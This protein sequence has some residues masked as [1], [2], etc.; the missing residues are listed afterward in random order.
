MNTFMAKI[1]K[2]MII[3]VHTD[4]TRSTRTVSSGFGSYADFQSQNELFS[5]A[6]GNQ[7]SYGK[8]EEDVEKTAEGNKDDKYAEKEYT[9]IKAYAGMILTLL[10]SLSFSIVTLLVFNLI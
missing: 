1:M 8:N 7:K 5:I 3:F 9:G 4:D 2:K 10:A 6:K